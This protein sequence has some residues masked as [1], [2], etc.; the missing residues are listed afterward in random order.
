VECKTCKSI[1]NRIR[2]YFDD[3]E[4]IQICNYCADF[5]SSSV[6]DV[7]WDGKPEINLADDE[8][9]G[10]PRVF[11]SKKEK[12]FYLKEKG[13]VEA[14][15]RV[16]GAPVSHSKEVANLDSRHEVKKVLKFLKEMGIDQRRQE[17]LKVIKNAK[18]IE[19]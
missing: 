14:G 4:I 12:Y 15:D 18:R 11:S 13:L 3:N 1:T 9:T 8:K 7:Y 6:Y 2:F 5:G 16:H 19:S 10:N 17:Y